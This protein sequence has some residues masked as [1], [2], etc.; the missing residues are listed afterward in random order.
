[1]VVDL[2]FPGK[3]FSTAPPLP[4]PLLKKAFSQ[5]NKKKIEERRKKIIHTLYESTSAITYFQG[6]SN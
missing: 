1:V 6:S 3:D 2:L 4:P 5:T